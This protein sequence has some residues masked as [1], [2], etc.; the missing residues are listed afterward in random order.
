MKS[1]IRKIIDTLGWP[2]IASCF[3]AIFAAAA[4]ALTVERAVTPEYVRGHPDEFS[5]D[6]TQGK[7]GLI[8][9]TIK[10]NVARPMYHV[11][12][13]AIYHQGK[14]MATIDMPSFGKKQ[15]NTF[16]FSISADD[17]AES[18]FDL[19]DSAL[20]GTGEDAVPVPGTIIHQF[21][22]LDF[23]PEQML[24]SAVKK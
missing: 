18:K 11:A 20:A 14:L 15:G 13:L 22:L 24:K 10:H 9:F 8:N 21:R 16:D 2:I 23:V 3:L 1:M 4:F 19:S 12:H 6:V 17:I 5:V 7:D